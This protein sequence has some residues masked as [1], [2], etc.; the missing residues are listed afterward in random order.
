MKLLQIILEQSNKPKAVIMAGGGGAG[1]SFILDKLGLSGLNVYNPDKYVEKQGQTLAA[2]SSIVNKEVEKAVQDRESFIWDTTGG[3]PGKVQEI[4]EAGYDVAMVMVYTHPIISFIAN[5][6]RQERS[7]PISA[8]LSTWRNTYSLI[9]TY[10]NMLGDQFYLIPNLRG[11]KYQREIEQFNKAARAGS[12]GIEDFLGNLKQEDPDRYKSTFSK[13]F[14]L[15]DQEEIEAYQVSTK[16]LKFDREDKDMVKNLQK[17]FDGFWQKGK[18]PP[19]GS[20]EKKV[21]AIER[22]R[23]SSKEASKQVSSDISDML[24]S[25]EFKETVLSADSIEQ[26]RSNLQSFLSR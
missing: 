14:E 11:D 24:N 4:V 19:S 25:D 3:N 17:H 8:V 13:P 21:A 1:K 20:M 18:L 12:E 23:V 26:V 22:G 10:Q 2:A 7:L 16:D 9:D 5:F 15:T 6:D